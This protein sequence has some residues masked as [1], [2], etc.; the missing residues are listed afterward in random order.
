MPNKTLWIT[1]KWPLPADDGAR[2]ATVSLLSS[3]TKRGVE[4]DLLAVAGRSEVVDTELAKRE[5][6]VRNVYIVRRPELNTT[7]KKLTGAITKVGSSLPITLSPYAKKYVEREIHEIISASNDWDFLLYDGL[8]PAAHSER[9]GKFYRNGFKG[10]IIYR[11]HNRESALWWGKAALTSSYFKRRFYSAQAAKVQRF[12][13][14]LV[15]SSDLVAAVSEIDLEGFRKESPEL[16]ARTVPIGLPFQK[17]ATP[18]P[19]GALRLL[20]IG[21]LDWAPNRE[22][23]RWFLDNVWPNVNAKR[24]DITLSVAGSGDGSWLKAYRQLNNLSV[25]GRVDDLQ[26]LYTGSDALIVPIFY[27][28]GT[29]V[30]VIEAASYSRAAISTALGVEGLNLSASSEYLRAEK[31]QEWI[32]LLLNLKREEL[33]SVGEHSYAKL[34]SHF[35]SDQVARSF[36]DILEAT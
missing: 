14:S 8:H 3:I 11:A 15:R 26:S 22:G 4:V 1:P 29:R 19:Q 16:K 32:N 23:L 33:K 27:G 9:S 13:D 31:A 20:F 35:D 21:K 18:L 24:S 25:L 34:K 6:G 7:S 36:I 2:K 28:S 17:T 30:K 5:L 12:E 10:K